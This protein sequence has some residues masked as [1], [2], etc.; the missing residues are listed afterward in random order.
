MF[1]TKDVFIETSLFSKITLA[2][3][4]LVVGSKA[5]VCS[6]VDIHKSLNAPVPAS[7]INHNPEISAALVVCR[8]VIVLESANRS[9]FALKS[10]RFSI[11]DIILWMILSLIHRRFHL[12]IIRD[13]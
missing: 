3:V 10:K 12:T 11:T 7:R 1:G 4:H 2:C 13:D 5:T 9:G 8:F 6:D